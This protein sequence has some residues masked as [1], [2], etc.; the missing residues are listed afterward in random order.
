[1]SCSC[2]RIVVVRHR[3]GVPPPLSSCAS[4]T[5]SVP[6]LASTSCVRRLPAKRS[7]IYYAQVVTISRRVVLTAPPLL[8]ATTLL[9]GGERHH[10]FAAVNS[11][12]SNTTTTTAAAAFRKYVRKDEVPAFDVHSVVGSV[13]DYELMI[14]DETVDDGWIAHAVSR[15]DGDA[16][17]MDMQVSHRAAGKI[18]VNIYQH[19]VPQNST[20]MA[21]FLQWTPLHDGL[22]LSE[23]D[24]QIIQDNKNKYTRFL[25]T[26]ANS[27]A[28]TYAYIV[29][30]PRVS[31]T[32]GKEHLYVCS[33][34]ASARQWKKGEAILRKSVDSFTF[35]A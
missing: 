13:M 31:E 16:Y 34:T 19:D 26:P 11:T 33:G 28:G 35:T 10:A 30:A 5:T 14:P 15:T 8:V 12:S 20:A 6:R 2:S 3:G 32:S 18:T 29:V 27:E 24:V 9:C 1:M 23:N 21:K 25:F 4:T 7:A 17:A 22:D